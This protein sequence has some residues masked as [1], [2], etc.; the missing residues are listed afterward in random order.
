MESLSKKGYSLWRGGKCLGHFEEEGPV[1]HHGRRTGAVGILAPT[2]DIKDASSMMQT[3]IEMLPHSPTFEAQ[4]PIEWIG[5]PPER[6]DPIYPSSGA[7]EPLSPEA[8]RGVSPDKMYEIR[9][10]RGARVDVQLVTLQLHR[11]ATSTDAKEWCEANGIQDDL[12]EFWMVS[13]ASLSPSE[14][15]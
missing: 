5:D 1:T 3:R 15:L 13:F 9:D 14:E 11:F 2:E 7:L 12:R 4:L 10:E 6:Q 8:A